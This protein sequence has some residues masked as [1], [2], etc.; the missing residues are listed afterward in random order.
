MNASQT[1][2]KKKS[3]VIY[4]NQSAF[5]AQNNPGGDCAQATSTC[6]YMTSTCNKVFPSYENKYSYYTGYAQCVSSCSASV[7]PTGTYPF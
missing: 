2:Y 3:V 7:P 1:T 6:C 5:Y 4:V